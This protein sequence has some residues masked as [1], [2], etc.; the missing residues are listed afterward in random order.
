MGQLRLSHSSL[1]ILHD[2]ERKFQLE[3]R[4]AG[5]I[6]EQPNPVF[7]RGH[8]Y[9]AG[10]QYYLLTGDMDYAIYK[11]WEA[12]WPEVE[13]APKISQARTINN[14]LRSKEKM[15]WIREHYEVAMFD[16]KP[17]IELGF[18]LNVNEHYYFVGFIDAVLRHKKTGIYGPV[19]MKTTHSQLHDLR[20]MFKNSGQVLGYSIV[21]DQI[22]GEEQSQYD[23][24]YLVCQEPKT[25][26]DPEVH[27][28]DFRKSLVDRLSWFMTLGMDIEKL[29]WMEKAG[30]YPMRG[31]SCLAFNRPCKYFGT[32]G[33]TSFDKPKEEE[34]DTNEYQF[35]FD[36]QTVIANHLERV[37]Q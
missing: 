29:A 37:R 18:R 34:P 13:D 2:C 14:L 9:G 10:T 21:V 4:L 30:F 15:D 25:G 31:D 19:D 17:A 5:P 12:Y 23:C 6:S 20:P 11:A 35:V 1:G 16:G 32:C 24:L 33:M 26:Y 22:A 27:W 28:F 8:S 3:K 36:L 7:S